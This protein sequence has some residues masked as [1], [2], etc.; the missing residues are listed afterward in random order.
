[1]ASVNIAITAGNV[2][3]TM[4]V[5]NLWIETETTQEGVLSR[6]DSLEKEIDYIRNDIL[7]IDDTDRWRKSEE[8]RYQKGQERRDDGQ[9]VDIKDLEGLH[10][11]EHGINQ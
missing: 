2:G 3:F 4:S 1:M 5:M 8:L 7:K 6:L 11:Y 10:L 9:D